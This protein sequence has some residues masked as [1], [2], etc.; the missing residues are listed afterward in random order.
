MIKHEPDHEQ[1][2]PTIYQKRYASEVITLSRQGYTIAQIC[3]KWEISER[4]FYYWKGKNE[5][6]R[7]CYEIGKT[8]HKGF[9]EGLMIDNLTSKHFNSIGWSMMMRSMH[10]YSETRVVELEDIRQHE[11]ITDKAKAIMNHVASGSITPQE[12]DTMIGTLAKI[13]KINLATDIE[14][15]IGIL[16][17]MLT[18][19]EEDK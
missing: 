9:M 11:S 10:S 13:G 7:E 3:A 1:G 12:G 6:F 15:K 16:Q 19:L 17:N 5:I 18:Q 4:T 2:R 14:E 8:A